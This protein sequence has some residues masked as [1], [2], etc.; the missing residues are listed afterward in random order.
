M[1]ISPRR[2]LPLLLAVPGLALGACGGST[3]DS[4]KI[5]DLIKKIDK[6]PAAACDNATKQ[7]LTQLSNDPAKCKAAARGYPNSSHITGG[8][9]VSVS[10]DKA[11]AT[12]KTSSG[13]TEHPTFVKQ[14]GKW[15]VDTTQ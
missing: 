7:L 1:T 14:N 8:I 10:G 2:T 3:S 15:L 13:Q 9:K 4:S 11:T 5:T 12:F 6:D